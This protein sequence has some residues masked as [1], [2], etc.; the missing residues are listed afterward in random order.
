M[1]H[2]VKIPIA[3][4]VFA[5]TGAMRL[6]TVALDGVLSVPKADCGRVYRRRIEGGSSEDGHGDDP[7]ALEVEGIGITARLDVDRHREEAGAVWV[8]DQPE[9]AAGAEGAQGAWWITVF[10]RLDTAITADRRRT[11]ID[12]AGGGGLAKGGFADTVAA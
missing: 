3:V 7:F 11:T 2:E 5:M 1:E 8:A 10:P 12:W 4:H 6:G 9:G